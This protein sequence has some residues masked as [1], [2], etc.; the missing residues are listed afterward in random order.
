MTLILATSTSRTCAPFG[1]VIRTFEIAST[2]LR[3]RSGRRTT[4]GKRRSPSKISVDHLAADCRFQHV[5]DIGDVDAEAGDRLPVD[6]DRSGTAG[7]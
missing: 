1:E 4:P 6:F 2:L 5:I 3:K 7:R